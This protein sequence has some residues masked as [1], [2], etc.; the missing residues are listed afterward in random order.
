M[1]IYTVLQSCWDWIGK[2]GILPL[3][4]TLTPQYRGAMDR[5]QH[6]KN[7]QAKGGTR[8]KYHDKVQFMIRCN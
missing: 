5:Q 8:A 3:E 6:N 2:C 1:G 7:G 4:S